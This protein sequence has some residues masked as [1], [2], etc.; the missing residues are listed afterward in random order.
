MLSL[1]LLSEVTYDH[2]F[3]HSFAKAANEW[4]PRQLP[5]CLLTREA[6]AGQGREGG[7]D[8]RT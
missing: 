3:S 6:R 5:R 4:G 8:S 7:Q 1:A 2:E